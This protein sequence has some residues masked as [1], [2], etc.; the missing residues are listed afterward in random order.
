GCYVHVGS[1]T[2]GG[3]HAG[4]LV[5]VGAA[6]TDD[7]D[8]GVYPPGAV[9]VS[10]SM[11]ADPDVTGY[12]GWIG[13]DTVLGS[14]MYATP[15]Y[16][17]PDGEADRRV[18][19]QFDL[20]GVRRTGGRE[21]RSVRNDAGRHRQGHPLRLR[22]RRRPRERHGYSDPGARQGAGHVRRSGVLP[23]S[24]PSGRRPD[25]VRGVMVAM[26]RRLSTTG[27]LAAA[28]ALVTG[29]LA[30]APGEAL[31]ADTTATMA[32]TLELGSVTAGGD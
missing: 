7:P 15:Y 18:G 23:A 6:S 19:P 10:G 12:G 24:D 2:A 27:R 8:T 28:A 11:E 13:G 32:C 3:D 31:A 14:S 26:P 1:V 29:L 9:R 16:I 25:A 4:K 5:T 22:V 30:W 20:A 17:T 21:M